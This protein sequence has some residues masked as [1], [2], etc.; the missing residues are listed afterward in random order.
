MIKSKTSKNDSGSNTKDAVGD[1]PTSGPDSG[2]TGALLVNTLALEQMMAYAENLS[3]YR[4][5]IINHLGDP[6]VPRV[7]EAMHVS[8][9]PIIHL[10][11]LLKEKYSDVDIDKHGNHLCV[12]VNSKAEEIREDIITN[13]ENRNQFWLKLCQGLSEADAQWLIAFVSWLNLY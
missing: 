4:K 1:A 11:N 7:I 3:K 13:F 9:E 10:S 8:R 12:L 6:S 5:Y 2:A